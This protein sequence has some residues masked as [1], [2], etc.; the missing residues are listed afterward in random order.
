MEPSEA[1]GNVFKEMTTSSVA[2]VISQ[3]IFSPETSQEEE[4]LPSQ[5]ENPVSPSFDMFAP[6]L[7]AEADT[8]SRVVVASSSA[9]SGLHQGFVNASSGL[10]DR[11]D[12]S[13]ESGEKAKETRSDTAMETSSDGGPTAEAC[14]SKFAKVDE[15]ERS[16]SAKSRGRKIG[17]KVKSSSQSGTA[18]FMSAE[19]GSEEDEEVDGGVKEK[20]VIEKGEQLVVKEVNGEVPMAN[21]SK[22]DDEEG[23]VTSDLNESVTS[24]LN[25][26]VTSALKTPDVPRLVV[27][28]LLGA[29]LQKFG[30]KHDQLSSKPQKVTAPVY[31]KSMKNA[32]KSATPKKFP[33]LARK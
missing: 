8:R 28:G 2:D 7:E 29:V 13:L 14:Q 16:G 22:D 6:S 3:D 1:S 23:S 4:P 12:A 32:K 9:S 31:E 26:S 25:R 10:M 20:E 30:Q 27:P 15:V 24:D 21:S 11:R 19:S 18:S 17:S 5:D 33:K